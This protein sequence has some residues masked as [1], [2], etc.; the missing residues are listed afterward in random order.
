MYFTIIVGFSLHKTRNYENRNYMNQDEEEWHGEDQ[1]DN[2]CTACGSKYRGEF[3][4]ICSCNY[5]G[6]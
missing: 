2:Y 4:L 5:E 1:A 6:D 3:D